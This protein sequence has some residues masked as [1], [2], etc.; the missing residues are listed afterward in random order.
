VVI[1]TRASASASELV[2]AGLDPFIPVTV[3]GDRTYGKPVGQ[4]GFEFCDKV[5]FPVSF[6][7]RNAAGQTDYFDG[8]PVDC[9]ASDNLDRALGDPAESSLAEALSFLRT[10]RCSASALQEAQA[11]REPGV[12][13][14]GWASLLNAH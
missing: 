4:Y 9:P 12:R 3:V 2:I 10:G 14:T 6:R 1:A 8:L 7:S 11:A 13:L 5:L